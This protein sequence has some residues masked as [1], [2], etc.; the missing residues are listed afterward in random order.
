MH[1]APIIVVNPDLFKN[2][3]RC[4]FA[5]RAVIACVGAAWVTRIRPDRIRGAQEA[6]V[7]GKNDSKVDA[8]RSIR[9]GLH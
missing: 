1:V 2:D 9:S 4:L 7:V 6:I 5:L 3:V 8:K